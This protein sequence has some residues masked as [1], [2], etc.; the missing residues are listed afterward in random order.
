MCNGSRISN[1]PIQAGRFTVPPMLS[2][3]CG[4]M[5]RGGLRDLQRS[6]VPALADL[7]PLASGMSD[8]SHLN[9]LVAEVKA[10]HRQF[11]TGVTIVT[12]VVDGVPYGLAVNAFSSLSLDPP[13]V[14]VCVATT[15]ATYP[16]LFLS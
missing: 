14:L 10:V 11:P 9:G 1:T 7:L 8:P 4:R 16:R 13:T 12:T 15:S 3:T 2:E 6:N 5:I